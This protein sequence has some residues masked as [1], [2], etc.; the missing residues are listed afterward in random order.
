M[1]RCVDICYS[2]RSEFEILIR[3]LELL[4]L[5]VFKFLLLYH[6]VCKVLILVVTVSV[7]NLIEAPIHYDKFILF[8]HFLPVSPLLI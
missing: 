4:V 5:H 2:T 8:L 6:L 3:V 7:H 1:R